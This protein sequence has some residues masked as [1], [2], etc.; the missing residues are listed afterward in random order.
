MDGLL[1]Y[2]SLAGDELALRIGQSGDWREFTMYRTVTHSGN[3]TVTFA[4]TGFG[5]AW[6]D[7]VTV[8]PVQMRGVAVDSP[9]RR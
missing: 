3:L 2:D 8:S 6:L 4:L 5:E 7:N 1:V 9:P